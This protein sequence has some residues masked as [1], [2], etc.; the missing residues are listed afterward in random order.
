[1]QLVPGVPEEHK[2]R[3]SIQGPLTNANRTR[4]WHMKSKIATC[5]FRCSTM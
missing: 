3:E 5:A 2:L 4:Y 1:M